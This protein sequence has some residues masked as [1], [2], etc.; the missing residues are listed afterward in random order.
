MPPC[1]NI[2]LLYPPIIICQCFL[3]FL[4]ICYINYV[5]P[6]KTCRLVSMLYMRGVPSRMRRVLLIS[7]GMVLLPKSSTL[8][9]MP[10]AFIVLQCGTAHRPFPTIIFQFAPL[11]VSSRTPR[12]SR[13]LLLT[14][15]KRFRTYAKP[16]SC[17][18]I[19][20]WDSLSFIQSPICR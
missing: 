4:E 17:C 2:Y 18:Q 16:L 14:A 5:S 20:N 15:R 12:H 11:I 8:L 10:V 1:I 9:T 13:G 19:V 6:S 3:R 7:L